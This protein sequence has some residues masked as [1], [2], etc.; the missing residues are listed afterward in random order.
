MKIRMLSVESVQF[1]GQAETSSEFF[2]LPVRVQCSPKMSFILQSTSRNL[3]P[4]EDE[5][6][7]VE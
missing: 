5:I 3:H 1:R 4:T 6:T 7:N 2:C